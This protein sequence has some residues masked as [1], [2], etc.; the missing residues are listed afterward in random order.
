VR[1][2]L[3][4]IGGCLAMGLLV[5]SSASAQA[6]F[7][8]TDSQSYRVQRGDTLLAL[9]QRYLI[10][11]SAVGEVQQLNRIANPRRIPVGTRLM[12]P[13]RLLRSVPVELRLQSFSGPVTVSKDNRRFPPQA[14]MILPEG[15]EVETGAN[16][17]IAILAADGSR[18]ALPSNSHARLVRSRRYLID[19]AADIDVQILRGRTEVHAAPQNPG[20]TFQVRTPVAVSA[21]RGTEFRAAL[22]ESVGDGGARSFTEVLEGHVGVNTP[23]NQDM[24]SAGFGAAATASGAIITETLLAPPQLLAPGK[25]QTEDALKFQMQPLAEA[26]GYLLEVARDAGFVETIAETE[27]AAPEGSFDSLPNGTYFVRVR[28]RAASGLTGL[29][30]AWSFRRQRAGLAG[31]AG[32]GSAPGA[33]RFSWQSTGEGTSLYRF[34]LF[35]DPASALPLIDEAGLSATTLNLTGLQKGTYQ[36]RS[37]LIQTTPDGSVEVW[38]PLQKINITN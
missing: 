22:G 26:R 28:A 7:R 10:S 9:G 6:A 31:D 5:P 38:M 4:L 17:F 19:R 14:G 12:I 8:A 29:G 23:A 34:Q 11:T 2:R 24:V 21:V 36:W 25:V 27:S 3:I 1:K 37:G 33:F 35:A 32:P 16:G 13:R 18:I 30:E 20:G 15:S